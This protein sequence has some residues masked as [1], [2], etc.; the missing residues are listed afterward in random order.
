MADELRIDKTLK[1]MQSGV[2][3]GRSVFFHKYSQKTPQGSPVRSRYVV[4]YVD[5]ASGWYSASV[6][7]IIYVNSYNIEPRYNGTRLCFTGNDNVWC[8]F[9]LI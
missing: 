3:V 1:N 7:V 4:S 9:Q 8:I 2:V 5:P 6:P